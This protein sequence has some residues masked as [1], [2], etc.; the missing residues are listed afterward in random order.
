[1]LCFPVVAAALKKLIKP[2]FGHDEFSSADGEAVRAKIDHMSKEWRSGRSA[3]LSDAVSQF[4]YLYEYSPSHSYL[5]YL[6]FSQS[7]DVRQLIRNHRERGGTLR[8]CCLGGGPGT[9]IAGLTR[10]I[11][12]STGEDESICVL[13]RNV[14]RAGSWQGATASMLEAAHEGLAKEGAKVELEA[15]TLEADL[16]KALGSPSEGALLGHD[17]YV[18]N[19]VCSEF[20]RAPGSFSELLRTVAQQLPADG[21]ILICDREENAVKNFASELLGSAGLNVTSDR[22]RRIEYQ[23]DCEEFREFQP[24]IDRRVKTKFGEAGLDQ[25]AFWMTGSRAIKK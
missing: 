15:E 8:V 5:A 1:M 24:K 25:G 19:H 10:Y 21:V 4:G 6:G 22:V 7:Q 16:T 13:F 23:E 17:L 2:T 3:D 18:L 14:D 11:A 20:Y 12:A 9:E